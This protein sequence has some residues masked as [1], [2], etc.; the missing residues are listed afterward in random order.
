MDT[1]KNILIYGG[2]FWPKNPYFEY[3]LYHHLVKNKENWD[4]KLLFNYSDIRL[5]NTQ[6]KKKTLIKFNHE[7][8]QNCKI[9]ILYRFEDLE[10]ITKKFDIFICTNICV[11]RRKI[12]F[13]KLADYIKCKILVIDLFGYD[14]VKKNI[15][16][17]ADYIFVKGKI[18]KEWLIKD[19]FNKNN[20]F[21]TGSIYF[22]YYRK[23]NFLNF[24]LSKIGFEKKYKL[25]SDKKIICITST[26]LCSTRIGMNEENLN[27]II[28]FIRIFKYKYNFI[29]LSYPQ[30]Y[31]FYEIDKTLRRSADK[32]NKPDY[33]YIKNL[34][35]NIK[36]IECQDNIN[37]CK[38]CDKI[39]HLSVGAFS[40]ELLYYFDK[41][42]FTMNFKNKDYYKKKI[43]YSKHVELPD[44]ICNIHLDRIEDL[45][46]DYNI[47]IEKLK[48][49]ISHFYKKDSRYHRN[50]I[51][52]LE[53][54]L[55]RV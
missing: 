44:D 26:N 22:D 23:N 32:K 19:K 24:N 25:E 46:K 31:L 9:K 3:N 36:L 30:D 4:V 38:Y 8:Y 34:V 17:K 29:L 28:K 18:F 52:T 33:S 14:I 1:T 47:D 15:F 40:S 51:I 54:L 41:I 45:D 5:T 35:P 6:K 42:S 43:G 48:N 50:F 27:E 11:D 37:A 10:F 49:K 7:Y 21:V 55:K 2:I 16:S 20:I 12:T 13:E 39:F 53:E